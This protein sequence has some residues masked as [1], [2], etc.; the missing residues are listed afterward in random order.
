M[1]IFWTFLKQGFEHILDFSAYDHILFI[2][3]LCAVYLIKD[4]K[5]LVILVTAFTIGHSLT[6]ALVATDF[7]RINPT[8]VEVLIPITIILTAL[9]NLIFIQKSE[10]NES[11]RPNYWL[12]LS[13][14]F[15]H[16]MG[17]SNYFRSILGESEDL[18]FS[19]FSFNIGVEVGQ[20]AI[21]AVI[22]LINVIYHRIFGGS[23]K[24][25]VYIL[26]GAGILIAINLLYGLLA[27]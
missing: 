11:L 26:S 23:Y 9:Y 10:Q 13:F 7:I 22:L 5:K 16:G 2:T 19:L 25:W 6:L 21:V 8:V 17:F 1:D 18:V 14:G 24:W 12:A 27:G 20:L 3:V 4:W 15:I